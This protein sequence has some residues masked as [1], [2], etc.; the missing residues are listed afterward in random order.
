MNASL[1]GSS[2][3]FTVCDNRGASHA[4]V[5]IVDLSGRPRLAKMNR[6]FR[7]NGFSLIEILIALIVFSVGLLTVAGLQT[8][9]KQAN[10]ESLQRTAASQIAHGLL[11]DMRIN[12]PDQRETLVEELLKKLS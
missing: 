6:F 7:Q 2:G 12:K 11:E 5:M 4:K 10:F 3:A 1:N 9:S 8:I